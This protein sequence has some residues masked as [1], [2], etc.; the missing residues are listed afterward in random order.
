MAFYMT[1][2]VAQ[3]PPA[4][5]GL[6]YATPAMYSVAG[7]YNPDDILVGRFGLAFFLPTGCPPCHELATWAGNNDIETLPLVFITNSPGPELESW[8]QQYPN[9]NVIVDEDDELAMQLGVQEAPSI[10][11]VERARVISRDTWPFTGGLERLAQ[12]LEQ[13]GI[14]GSTHNA[15][16]HEQLERLRNAALPDIRL[17]DAAGTETHLKQFTDSSIL[18]VCQQFCSACIEEANYINQLPAEV[19]ENL[20]PI[21]VLILDEPEMQSGAAVTAEDA[22]AQTG[23]ASITRLAND[24]PELEPIPGTPTHIRIDPGG[25]IAWV[26]LG[27]HPGIE[28]RLL[29]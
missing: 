14:D 13:F 21:S 22:W 24:S 26:Y 17:I 19:K 3:T 29:D 16:V 27:F 5:P 8:I 11:L 15:R 7:P 23:V 12:E 6:S 1:T 9:L 28:T 25:V 18:I 4:T 2:A 10:Y 20:L